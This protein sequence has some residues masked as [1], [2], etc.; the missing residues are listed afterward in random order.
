MAIGFETKNVGNVV[1]LAPVGKIIIGEEVTA[2][3]EKIQELLEQ[4]ARNILL[5]LSSV[6]YFDSTGVGTL[7]GSFTTV[8]RKDGQMKLS[9]LQDRVRD[10]LLVTKLLTVFDVYENE[11]EG[12]KSFS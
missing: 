6:T 11:G 7:G 9:G 2:L 3:R 4:G 1:V 8:R 12:I 5:N 10:I